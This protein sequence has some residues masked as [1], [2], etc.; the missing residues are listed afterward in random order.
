MECPV[1]STNRENSPRV[2]SYFPTANG[3]PI[4]TRRTGPS[5]SSR[6]SSESGEPME[7]APTGTTTISGH[8]SQS[9]NVRPAGHLRARAAR[10]RS[11]SRSLR[12]RSAFSRASRSS[13]SLTSSSVMS[14]SKATMAG[15]AF[16]PRAASA[17]P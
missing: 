9:R 7:N 1:A 16:F 15:C 8:T 11:A 10:S 13:S 14:R 5:S 17:S 3:A 12:S 2:T 6:P 4:V